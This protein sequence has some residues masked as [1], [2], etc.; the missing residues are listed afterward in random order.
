MYVQ[1][2]TYSRATIDAL[3][4]ASLI[5]AVNTIH[6]AIGLYFEQAVDIPLTFDEQGVFR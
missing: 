5:G 1:Y 2:S 3:H 6:M 4:E